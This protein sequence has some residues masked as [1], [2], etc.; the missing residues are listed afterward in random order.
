MFTRII[1]DSERLCKAN[2]DTGLR[3]MS[4]ASLPGLKDYHYL[5]EMHNIS[6]Q[7]IFNHAANSKKDSLAYPNKETN[8]NY[9]PRVLHVEDNNQIRFLVEIL[10]R[11]EFD[12]VGIGSGE[13]A[14]EMIKSGEFDIILMDLNLGDGISGFETTIRIK[15]IN[16]KT[17]HIP[18]IALTANNY[19]DVREECVKV[20]MNAFIQKPFDRADLTQTINQLI[21]N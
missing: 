3:K 5:P 16:D 8:G 19:H 20:G 7:H 13:K 18:V 21:A 10:L 4:I 17:K 9:K 14:L 1:F 6:G 12:V 15:A 11:K 2:Q